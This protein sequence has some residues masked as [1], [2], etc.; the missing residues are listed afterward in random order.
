MTDKLLITVLQQ[1]L[2]ELR[3]TRGEICCKL[4]DLIT[5]TEAITPALNGTA[6]YTRFTIGDGNPGTPL[7]GETEY[8]D[9]ALD[10]LSFLVY[11]NGAGYLVEDVDY[12]ILPG[13]GFEL[14]GGAQFEDGTTYTI[15]TV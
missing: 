1:I 8:P 9:P 15:F 5:A 3:I 13:G 6:L 14:L 4:R 12:S 2:N 7:N 10:G 11:L